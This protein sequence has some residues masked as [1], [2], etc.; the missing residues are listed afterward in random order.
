[1]YNSEFLYECGLE[2]TEFTFRCEV[3]FIYTETRGQYV[4]NPSTDRVHT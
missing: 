4:V 3:S 1:M 2:A